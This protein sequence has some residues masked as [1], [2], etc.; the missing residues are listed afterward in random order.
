M[1][2]CKFRWTRCAERSTNLKLQRPYVFNPLNCL[3]P[4]ARYRK[5]NAYEYFH[6]QAS[7]FESFE[8]ILCGE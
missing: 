5:R 1:P 7:C 8:S 4:D 2:L 3:V 6:F